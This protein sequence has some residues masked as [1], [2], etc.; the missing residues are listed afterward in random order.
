MKQAGSDALGSDTATC[1][2]L[3]DD[4]TRLVYS[5]ILDDE[6]KDTAA[7]FWERANAFYADHG[8]TVQRVMTDKGSCYRSKA[9]N[10]AVGDDVKH[11][12]DRRPTG[13]S[14]GSTSPSPTNGPTPV[15]TTQTI[16]APPATPP[17]F[18][19]TVITDPTASEASHPSIASTTSVGR[20][21]SQP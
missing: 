11:K 13:R 3:I 4:N 7:G 21:P 19:T 9:F 17:G 16:S 8:I 15:T 5:E 20:T 2:P 12:Y 6:R 18:T 10:E 1:I 14:N